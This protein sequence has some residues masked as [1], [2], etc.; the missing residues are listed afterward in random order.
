MQCAQ[1]PHETSPEESLEL[2]PV[3]PRDKGH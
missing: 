1:I 3:P 2:L